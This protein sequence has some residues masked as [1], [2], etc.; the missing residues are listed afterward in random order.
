MTTCERTWDWSTDG[1]AWAD[2]IARKGQLESVPQ[3]FE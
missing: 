2:A 1:K 3:R